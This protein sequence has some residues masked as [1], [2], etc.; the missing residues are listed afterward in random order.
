MRCETGRCP[1]HAK[2]RANVFWGGGE[3]SLH[4]ATDGVNPPRNGGVHRVVRIDVVGFDRHTQL[5]EFRAREEARCEGG[6]RGEGCLESG[7]FF[8]GLRFAVLANDEDPFDA[9]VLLASKGGVSRLFLEHRVVVRVHVGDVVVTGGDPFFE[10]RDGR[11]GLHQNRAA[12]EFRQL[13]GK[14]LPVD[15]DDGGRLLRYDTEGE[16]V[17]KTGTMI[18][19]ESRRLDGAGSAGRC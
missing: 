11:G 19:I 15:L 9:F 17:R 13:V 2:L 4:S 14:R 16:R 5:L 1:E 7:T 18:G 12:N 8:Q 10:L 6:G 3:G